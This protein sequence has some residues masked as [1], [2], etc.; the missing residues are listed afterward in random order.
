MEQDFEGEEKIS[1]KISFSLAGET[2][3]KDWEFMFI[4]DRLE[5]V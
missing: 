5:T 1:L 2:N 3:S 4:E